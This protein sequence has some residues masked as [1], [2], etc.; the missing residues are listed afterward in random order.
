MTAGAKRASNSQPSRNRYEH[1]GFSTGDALAVRNTLYL[2]R[3]LTA[4]AAKPYPACPAPDANVRRR[5]PNDFAGQAPAINPRAGGDY[6]L[7][8][9]RFTTAPGRSVHAAHEPLIPHARLRYTGT[10]DGPKPPAAM[11]VT[12]DPKAVSRATE[13]TLTQQGIANSMP[14]AACNPG[15]PQPREPMARPVEPDFR[16]HV[17][18]QY[19]MRRPVVA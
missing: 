2:H 10:S 1:P 13:I 15:S 4:R 18:R 9:A 11:P 6:R 8:V 12:V 14:H 16:R 7:C 5:P 17:Q 19:P 3:V